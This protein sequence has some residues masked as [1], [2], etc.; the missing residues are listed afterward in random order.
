VDAVTVGV[1]DIYREAVVTGCDPKVGV[2]NDKPLGY[3][4]GNY[5]GEWLRETAADIPQITVLN[6][7]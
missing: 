2:G 4:L 7:T 5:K 3:P 6:E 1:V